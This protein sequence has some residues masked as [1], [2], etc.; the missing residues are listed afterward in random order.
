MPINY[1]SFHFD[2]HYRNIPYIYIYLSHDLLELLDG[3]QTIGHVACPR[4]AARQYLLDAS[5]FCSRGEPLLAAVWK[6]KHSCVDS[7]LP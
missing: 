7:W 1:S 4:P 6:R 2:F 5:C 3:G